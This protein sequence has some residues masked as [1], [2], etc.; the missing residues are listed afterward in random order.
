MEQMNY[1][2]MPIV[3]QNNEE[4]KKKIDEAHVYAA[5]AGGEGQL[6]FNAITAIFSSATFEDAAG[7]A[8]IASRTKGNLGYFY[9]ALKKI[10]EAKNIKLEPQKHKKSFGDAESIVEI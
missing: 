2:K 6:F 7:A 3:G 9:K 1:L 4:A 5:K 10:R 8:E